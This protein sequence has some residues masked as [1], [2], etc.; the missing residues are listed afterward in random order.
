MAQS[1]CF[2]IVLILGLSLS[3]VH[4]V[5]SSN[6][7]AL[8]QNHLWSISHNSHDIWRRQTGSDKV[9]AV[10]CEDVTFCA[11]F[12][13]DA[14]CMSGILQLDVDT[15]LRCRTAS[16]LETLRSQ[17][18]MCA[19]SES[20]AHC[21]SLPLV[22]SMVEQCSG[23]ISSNNCTQECRSY[24]ENL[25]N[26]LGCCINEHSSIFNGTHN[27]I[28]SY[29]L[30]NLCEITVP[31]KSCREHGLTFNITKSTKNFTCTA[32]HPYNQYDDPLYYSSLCAKD[33][34]GQAYIDIM[35]KDKN[36][37]SINSEVAKL[38]AERCSVNSN[39]GFCEM[40]EQYSNVY[41]AIV[42]LEPTFCD[43]E[44]NNGTVG[45]RDDCRNYL[46]DVKNSLGCCINYFFTVN[47]SIIDCHQYMQVLTSCG[48]ESPEFCKSTLSLNGARSTIY[49]TILQWFSILTAIALV[50]VLRGQ[51]ELAL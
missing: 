17:Y 7:N 30:W 3:R 28:F 41:D 51:L 19:K 43:V 20:G 39:G 23:S 35:L 16:N 5:Q 49:T 15:V 9:L 18:S 40:E 4:Q 6:E 38:V 10:D 1:T 21:G 11:S 34:P 46:N 29:D 22:P 8:V 42:R 24:L 32:E 36:C 25:K 13:N 26:E 2:I 33:G 37:L 14:E 44:I 45:C 31:P 50:L 47:E 27:E 12:R 48:V